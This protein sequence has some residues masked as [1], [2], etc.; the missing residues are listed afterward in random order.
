MPIKLT[1]Q[2]LAEGYTNF[3]IDL[4]MT[5]VHAWNLWPWPVLP[6]C[7]VRWHCF[8][9]WSATLLWKPAS[10]KCLCFSFAL[11]VWTVLSNRK[12]P[13]CLSSASENNN[14]FCDW[15]SRISG[16][17]SLDHSSIPSPAKLVLSINVLILKSLC[18][19]TTWCKFVRVQ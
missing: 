9:K 6:Q 16:W 4:N 14:C 7:V 5:F 19:N 13:F 18:W 8:Y 2:T 15:W 17:C 1:L 12:E 10:L 11:A 3:L